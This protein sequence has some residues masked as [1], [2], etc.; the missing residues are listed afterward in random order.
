LSFFVRRSVLDAR[1]LAKLVKVAQH[2]NEL[3]KFEW[4]LALPSVFLS[5]GIL[6]VSKKKI[7]DSSGLVEASHHNRAAVSNRKAVKEDDDESDDDDD[8]E[9]NEISESSES[10][11]D[12]VDRNDNEN[13]T[14]G[15]IYKGLAFN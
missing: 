14:S 9:K 1:I 12:D 13:H 7:D 11:F 8:H 4:N 3:Q 6:K 2:R 5:N 10:S 15:V